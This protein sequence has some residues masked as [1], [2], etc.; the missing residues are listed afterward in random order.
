MQNNFIR[1]AFYIFLPLLLGSI[2][3]LIISNSLDYGIINKP[4]LSP[5]G[6]IFPIVWSILY[7]LMGLSYF[8]YKNYGKE[9]KKVDKI[10]YY[11][12]FVNLLWSIFFFVLKWRLFTCIWTIILLLLVIYLLILFFK[13]Y[14]PSFY[15]NIPYLIWL[16]FA[17]YLT[18]GVY[19]LN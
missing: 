17:T 14:K 3:G 15:L 4:F 6:Y 13:Y 11:Q 18:F 7:I 2:I 5:P 9:N 1:N 8:L 12:L 19:F 16:I 10:Y